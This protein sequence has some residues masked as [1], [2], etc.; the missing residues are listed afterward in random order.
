MLMGKHPGTLTGGLEEE[1]LM[2]LCKHRDKHS[3]VIK[4]TL[5]TCTIYQSARVEAPFKADTEVARQTQAAFSQPLLRAAWSHH[6]AFKPNKSQ[7]IKLSQLSVVL[8]KIIIIKKNQI[9]W[10][11]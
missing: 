5:F 2:N 9:L 8:Q 1:L 7:P 6:S 4:S 11:L 10:Q 3:C